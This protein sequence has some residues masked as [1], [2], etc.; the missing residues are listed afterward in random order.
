MLKSTENMKENIKGEQRHDVTLSKEG[1]LSCQ[2]IKRRN[3]VDLF[4]LIHRLYL[5]IDLYK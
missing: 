1:R 4:S 2:T 3:I 5:Y